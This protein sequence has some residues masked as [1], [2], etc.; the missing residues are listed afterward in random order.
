[1][2]T[3][4]T[5]IN[6]IQGTG[7][8]SPFVNTTVELEGVVT[9]NFQGDNQLKGFFISSLP[10]DD[11]TNPLTSEGI[12]VYFAAANVSVG[13]HVRVQG[14]VEEYFNATQIGS[15]TQV[16]VC[17]S[18]LTV[19][20]T[21][22]SLPVTNTTDL[23]AFEG[24]LI[25]L[26]QPLIVTNNFGLGRY[27][28]IELATERLYQGTQVALPGDAANTLEANNLTKKILLDDGSTLQNIEPIYPIP[29]LSAENT[30]RTGD[31]VNTVTAVFAYSF[32]N[33]RHSPYDNTAVY[34]LPMH[35]KMLPNFT[36]VTDL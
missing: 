34:S 27:G 10:V 11:D 9:A 26:E 25:T 28:E 16:A 7:A 30:L 24:M 15:V 1:M 18:G 22:I 20:A 21:K 36:Y 8:A 3:D 2:A 32:Y 19:S 13:D 33:H 6:A 29:G 35:V 14:S 23:E 31:T 5:T 12:F 4:K 17:N